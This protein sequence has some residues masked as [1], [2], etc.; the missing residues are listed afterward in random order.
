MEFKIPFVEEVPVFTPKHRPGL[1]P[2]LSGF[3]REVL[4]A[5]DV[6]EQKHDFV[7]KTSVRAYNLGIILIAVAILTNGPQIL[8]YVQGW[9][10]GEHTMSGADH[11]RK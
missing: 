1:D 3:E 9:I 4:D 6:L 8:G 11:F 5:I 10:T 2:G 7:A